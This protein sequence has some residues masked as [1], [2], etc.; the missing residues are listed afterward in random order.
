[1]FYTERSSDGF[2]ESLDSVFKAYPGKKEA[3]ALMRPH[4]LWA[5]FKIYKSL[6]TSRVI[7]T[8]DTL[9]YLKNFR[10][11]EGQRVF[12]LWHGCGVFRRFALDAPIHGT[13]LEEM[14]KHSQYSAVA[15]SSED[16]RQYFA[17]AFGISPEV[18]LPVG[19]PKTDL[20]LSSEQTGRFRSRLIKK[21]PLLKDK[22]I[23][24]YCP[25][26]RNSAL[27]QRFNPQIDWE[28]LNASLLPNEIFIVNRH[29]FMNE[30][31]FKKWRYRRVRDYTFEPTPELLAAA[32]VLITDYSTV[33]YD[34]CLL[35]VPTVFYCPDLDKIEQDFYLNIPE[36]LPGNTVFEPENLLDE[37]RN[38]LRNPPLEQAEAFRQKQ[39]SACDGKATK[40][41]VE[42]IEEWI[43]AN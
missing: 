14:R 12:Q 15:A 24:L 28:K 3:I 13:R 43:K 30:E 33:F 32:D 27:S 25:T 38:S 36:D 23:Y 39:L 4:S 17:H 18:V 42:I 11:R 41:T 1:M 40:R 16:C 8:D 35:K 10:L 29:P 22:K 21:H 37:I 26:K 34:A 6:L 5:R 19:T 2:S 20:L 31:F 9:H 7:V